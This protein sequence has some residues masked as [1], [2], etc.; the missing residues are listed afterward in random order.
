MSRRT[1]NLLE[2]RTLWGLLVGN[3]AAVQTGSAREDRAQ[4]WRNRLWGG[5]SGERKQK[6]CARSSCWLPP[7]W[8]PSVTCPAPK[9][10]HPGCW[11]LKFQWSV[12]FSWPKGKFNPKQCQEFKLTRIWL[13]RW[14]RRLHFIKTRVCINGRVGWVGWLGAG[15]GEQV[16]GPKNIKYIDL[17]Y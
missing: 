5:G 7:P 1:D 4:M 11:C 13:L 6:S 16:W 15:G 9:Q 12:S 2:E 14:I 17:L 8:I 10:I 3:M